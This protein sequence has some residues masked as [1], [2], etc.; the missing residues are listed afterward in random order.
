M[1]YPFQYTKT[2]FLSPYAEE[3]KRILSNREGYVP[4]VVDLYL[5]G[6]RMVPVM[7]RNDHFVGEIPIYK[8]ESTYDLLDKL[9]P[10]TEDQEYDVFFFLANVEEPLFAG[11][12][13]PRSTHPV[14]IAVN[15]IPA[16]LNGELPRSSYHNTH[17][18][19]FDDLMRIY[20]KPTYV[21]RNQRNI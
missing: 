6:G 21:V 3:R 20:L 17:I 5:S 11:R 2:S 9:V 19:L 12:I 8:R 18:N 1:S 15:Y 16:H 13:V 4:E 14:D 7:D 10:F